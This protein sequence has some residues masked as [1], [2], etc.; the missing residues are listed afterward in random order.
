MRYEVIINSKSGSGFFQD[1]EKQEKLRRIFAD[2]GHET[3]IQIVEP[4][5]LEHSIRKMAASEAEALIIGGG[6]GTITTA[7]NLLKGTGKVLGVLPLGTFNLEARDLHIA[8]DPF[9]AA[10]QLLD[11]ETIEIDLL[12]VNDECCLCATV[13]GFY[14]ALAKSREDFHGRSWWAKS[15]RIVR[16]IATVAVS[17]PALDLELSSEGKT[18]RR[19]T[20]L[21]AFSPGHYVESIGLIP[22]REDLASGKLSA[23]VSE[24]LTRLQ[25]LKAAFGF[26]T[27]RLFGTDEMTLI[28]SSEININVRRKKRIP[29]MIDGEIMDMDMPCRLRILPRALKVLRPRKPTT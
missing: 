1:A 5:D 26:L 20:R 25:M 21:A 9:E 14:P 17:S 6:D 3:R 23:Y 16:E 28:E 15:V 29:I 22:D 11:S 24:H 10:T 7:A 8:L 2:S 19:R 12:M 18:I 13:I 4:A 27:G